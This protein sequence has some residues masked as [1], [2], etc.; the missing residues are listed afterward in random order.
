[1]AFSN[2]FAVYGLQMTGVPESVGV[3][4]SITVGTGQTS[5]SLL[6]ANRAVAFAVEVDDAGSVEIDMETLVPSLTGVGVPQVETLTIVA[7]AGITSNGN[8]TVT[9]TGEH[10]A[11][12]PVELQIPVTTALT[13]AALIAQHIIDHA[14]FAA[15]LEEYTLS[16]STA[17]IVAEDL[18]IRTNDATFSIAVA[19]GL[20]VSAATS[21]TTTTGL[22]PSKCYRLAGATYGGE[23]FEGSDPG[24]VGNVYGAEFQVA[25]ASDAA[26]VTVE[27]ASGDFKIPMLLGMVF[28]VH[29]ASSPTAGVTVGDNLTFTGAGGFAK[30]VVTLAFDT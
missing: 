14:A 1:M 19:A 9:I 10:V 28:H 20:G 17:D 24:T 7:A 23:T 29:N 3:T 22:A 18:G 6:N 4:G 30:I 13:T 11:N 25:T 2:A 16:R 8:L 15:A 12:S 27:S 21:T 5:V 26:I